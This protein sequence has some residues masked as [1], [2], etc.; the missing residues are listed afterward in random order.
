ME[1]T[2]KILDDS[3][4]PGL[5]RQLGVNIG[6]WTSENTVK[7]LKAY[8]YD[9]GI[10]GELRNRIAFELSNR[11][12]WKE[13]KTEVHEIQGSAAMGNYVQNQMDSMGQGNGGVKFKA[14]N[15]INT[16][17][18]KPRGSEKMAL[19]YDPLNSYIY[20]KKEKILDTGHSKTLAKILGVDTSWNGW[21]QTAADDLKGIGFSEGGIAETLKT[22]PGKTGDDGWCVVQKGEAILNLPQTE[23]FKDLVNRL[24]ELSKTMELVPAGVKAPSYSTVT[25][26]DSKVNIGGMV[27]NIDGSKIRDLESLKKEIQHDNKFRDFMTDVVLGKVTGNNYAH[28]KY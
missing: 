2:G 17:A 25:N 7:A 12:G 26:N 22:V 6:D 13:H 24:P 9:G 10:Y 23:M 19:R 1:N 8:G 27:F 4:I 20:S 15:F 16:N 5:A 14:V 28:M 21:R 3:L 18:R 11:L